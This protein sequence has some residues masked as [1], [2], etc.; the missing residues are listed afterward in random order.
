MKYFYVSQRTKD[1]FIKD[2]K[3]NPNYDIL[4]TYKRIK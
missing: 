2:I 3:E 4:R 1:I